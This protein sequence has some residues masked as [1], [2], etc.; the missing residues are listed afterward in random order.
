[1]ADPLK[2]MRAFNLMAIGLA[3]AGFDQPTI[4]AFLQ[5]ARRDLGIP[6]EDAT[7]TLTKIEIALLAAEVR[8]DDSSVD[9]SGEAYEPRKTR[10]ASADSPPS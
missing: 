7:K 6:H 5:R 8:A 2:T 9:G 4:L 10:R 1:M 3:E